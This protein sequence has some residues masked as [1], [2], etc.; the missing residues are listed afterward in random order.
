MADEKRLEDLRS[1][2]MESI[3]KSEKDVVP[4]ENKRFNTD[5][6]VIDTHFK[7]QKVTVSFRKRQKVETFHI[8]ITE[9]HR[10]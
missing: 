2:I 7:R 10:Q 9:D 8:L 3:G 6:A 1:K 5:N 4:I